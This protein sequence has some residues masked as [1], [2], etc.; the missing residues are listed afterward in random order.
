MKK[1]TAFRSLVLFAFLSVFLAMSAQDK[2]AWVFRPGG[3]WLEEH[4]QWGEISTSGH[5]EYFYHRYSIP[6]DTIVNGENCL[7]LMYSAFGKAP[8]LYAILKTEGE[9]VFFKENKTSDKWLLLYDFGAPKDEIFQ[10]YSFYYYYH[11]DQDSEGKGVDIRVLSSEYDPEYDD[12]LVLTLEQKCFVENPEFVDPEL[13]DTW[14]TGRKWIYGIGTPWGIKYN[15]DF[16]VLS[17]S[18]S[19]RLI[20]A[21]VDDEVVYSQPRQGSETTSWFDPGYEWRYNLVEYAV[22]HEDLGDGKATLSPMMLRVIGN[23]T[24]EGKNYRHMEL[25]PDQ[26]GMLT[27][28]SDF[29]LREEHGA[30]YT[31]IDPD[32]YFHPEM[33]SVEKGEYLLYDFNLEAGDTFDAPVFDFDFFMANGVEDTAPD[34]TY[35]GVGM[36][37]FKVE[38][39]TVDEFGRRV[40]TLSGER[41]DNTFLGLVPGEI[42]VVEGVGPLSDGTLAMY[43]FLPATVGGAL[44]SNLDFFDILDEDGDIVY[45]DPV[46]RN[47]GFLDSRDYTWVYG[48]FDSEGDLSYR[49]MQFNYYW[50]RED[51]ESGEKTSYRR[52]GTV[53]VSDSADGPWE[54]TPFYSWYVRE[55]SGKV[56]N[57]QN[58]LL[59]DF[60]VTDCSTLTIYTTEGYVTAEIA[61]GL[62]EVGGEDKLSYTFEGS[63]GVKC[64]EGIG[65]TKGGI[66]PAVN[67]E[68][69]RPASA[70]DESFVGAVLVAVYDGEGNLIFRQDLPDAVEAISAPEGGFT[71]PEDRLYDLQGRELREP[72]PGQPYIKGGKVFVETK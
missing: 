1:E 34:S 55:E 4:V 62:T 70:D 36:C 50:T 39:K 2:K 63:D 18:G 32:K 42:K 65:I 56:W 49:K 53:G 35:P 72:V 5:E 68:F 57:G 30:W 37:H 47:A 40:L 20:E 7:K 45:L 41:M 19:V 15:A 28:L 23:E 46:Q 9:K 10:V 16:G 27:S 21:G 61:K 54:D 44:N 22:N 12:N 66:L 31:Y 59:Y 33:I 3:W 64:V 69:H 52:F 24:K 43:C 6:G 25:L 17:G 14:E 51:H 29:Y 38:S 67:T 26:T 71:A 13:L 60:N 48:V 8:E 58:N 11:F